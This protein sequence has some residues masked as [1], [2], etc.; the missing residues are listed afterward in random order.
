[1]PL[2]CLRGTS[3]VPQGQREIKKK[4]PLKNT[5]K[6]KKMRKEIFGDV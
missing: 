5:I 1:M 2:G 4:L 6:K 3:G